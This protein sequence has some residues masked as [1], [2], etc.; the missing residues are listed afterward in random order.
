MTLWRCGSPRG[1][2]EV[3]RLAARG[4]GDGGDAGVGVAPARGEDLT[5]GT[6]KLAGPSIWNFG[7]FM[8]FA[9]DEDGDGDGDGDG[10]DYDDDDDDNDD[11]EDDHPHPHPHP[12][13]QWPNW[14][15]TSFFQTHPCRRFAEV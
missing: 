4:A 14:R 2:G 5:L 10:D 12:Y 8:D 15:C 3:L 9:A 6:F 1:V 7:T 13:E 11:D